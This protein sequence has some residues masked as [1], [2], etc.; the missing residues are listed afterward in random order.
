MTYLVTGIVKAS[1]TVSNKT[2]KLENITYNNDEQIQV[3]TNQ[4]I[5]KSSFITIVLVVPFLVWWT[6]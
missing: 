4:L 1:F 5:F 2:Y 3:I 6:L